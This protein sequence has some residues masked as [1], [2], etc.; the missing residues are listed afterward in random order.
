LSFTN[1]PGIR[2]FRR[3]AVVQWETN[4][5]CSGK[6]EYGYSSSQ[7]NFVKNT[8]DA[9]LQQTVLLDSL[10]EGIYFYRVRILKDDLQKYSTVKSF[11]IT[12]ALREDNSPPV[13]LEKK[14][15]YSN[16]NVLVSLVFSEPA[17]AVFMY[18][19]QPGVFDNGHYSSSYQFEHYL[20]ISG[21]DYNRIYY[22]Q[23]IGTDI[24]GNTSSENGLKKSMQKSADDS[25]QLPVNQDNHAPV[26]LSEP[27]VQ[28]HYA[29]NLGIYWQA[30]EPAKIS[31][32][33]Y[34]NDL[35][36]TGLNS[37][38]YENEGFCYF[39][40]LDNQQVYI[41]KLKLSD[42]SNNVSSEKILAA[43]LNDDEPEIP[44]VSSGPVVESFEQG[45]LIRWTLSSPGISFAE[46]GENENQL[47]YSAQILNWSKEKYLFLNNDWPVFSYRLK[48]CILDNIC[49]DWSDVYQR[50]VPVSEYL[51]ENNSIKKC[52]NYP[53]PFQNSTV[54][55]FYVH[56]AEPIQ[57]D[58]FNSLGQ[59]IDSGNCFPV[60]KGM[61]YYTW[62]KYDI[63]LYPSGLYFFKIRGL[64]TNYSGKML[65][66]K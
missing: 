24:F 25:F 17:R 63:H 40:G 7:L 35:L 60:S 26:F 13:L 21:L 5:A 53:N 12:S 9:G 44:T 3:S 39:D 38:H 31:C 65:L 57:V 66:M 48:N 14:F 55:A 23:I 1:Y 50:S 62:P 2:L 47:N 18:G 22:Y 56:L 19:T 51:L 10:S 4:I 8:E 59:K 15:Y 33:V 58:I 64:Q 37:N 54:I 6:V 46:Y 11:Q 30:N 43:V 16:N 20:K 49:G 34:K 41:I 29:G 32:S 28:I 52:W 27:V 36:A 42:I 45:S 61:H